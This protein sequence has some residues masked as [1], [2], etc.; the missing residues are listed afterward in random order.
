MSDLEKL[1][2]ELR[3]IMEFF[4]DEESQYEAGMR[5]ACLRIARR[6]GVELGDGKI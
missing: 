1:V 6:M 5:Y 4:N 2:N 3:D